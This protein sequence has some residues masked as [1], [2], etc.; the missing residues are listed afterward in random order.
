MIYVGL[1]LIGIKR[2]LY[3]DW[4]KLLL[5]MFINIIFMCFKKIYFEVIYL[6]FFMIFG[7][8]RSLV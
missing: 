5:Y 3:N 2:L 7:F 4:F 1:C 6:I 8:L